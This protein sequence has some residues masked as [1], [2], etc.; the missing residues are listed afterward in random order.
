M[1]LEKS[2]IYQQGRK[3][4]NSEALNDLPRQSQNK[5]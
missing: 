4:T 5:S 2:N 3:D 1:K